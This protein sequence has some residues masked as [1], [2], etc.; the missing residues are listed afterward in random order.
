MNLQKFLM[1]TSLFKDSIQDSLNMTVSDDGKLNDTAVRRQL[2]TKFP[3]VMC[4]TIP[5]DAIFKDQAKFDNQNPIISSLLTQFEI[6]K[7]QKEKEIKNN[8]RLHLP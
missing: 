1:A 2:D 5:T 3:S 6:G 4:K 8:W 7:K